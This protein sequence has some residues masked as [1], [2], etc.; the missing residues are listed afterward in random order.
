MPEVSIIIPVYNPGHYLGIAVQSILAQSFTDWEL[1]IVDDGSTE[2]IASIVSEYPAIKLIRQKNSGQAIARNVGIL[3]ASGEYLAF[4]DQD[5]VWM[6][7]KLE[8]Q[9][10]RMRQDASLGLCHTQFYLIDS[11]GRK[12]GEG[13]GRQQS[14]EEMLQGSGICGSST[15]ML[16]REVCLACGMFDA[17]CQPAEDYDLWL[18]IARHFSTDFVASSEAGYRLHSQNQSLQYT[19]TY[20]AIVEILHK[21]ARIAQAK[22]DLIALSAAQYGLQRIRPT[23]G[24]QAF[25]QCRLSLRN[26][27]VMP[28]LTHLGFAFH[29]APGYVTRSLL[30]YAVQGWRR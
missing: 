22:G 20:Q 15:V 6:P 23:Y 30:T 19:Q 10:Q 18:R 26:R 1:I 29:H 11:E 16:R 25:D 13:F 27:K 7:T 5:D 24:T 9:A 14:Y 17:F 12:T 3:H 21:H 4:L 28:F 2:D 8:T